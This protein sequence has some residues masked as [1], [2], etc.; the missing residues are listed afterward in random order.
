MVNIWAGEKPAA[1]EPLP[2]VLVDE[3][4]STNVR[5][6]H[7]LPATTTGVGAATWT[8]TSGSNG[9]AINPIEPMVLECAVGGGNEEMRGPADITSWLPSAA[10]VQAVDTGM[11][12]NTSSV[13]LVYNK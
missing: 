7:A 12:A 13:V 8:S 9:L 10:L 4:G 6:R 3:L 11:A 1:I 5:K 2:V